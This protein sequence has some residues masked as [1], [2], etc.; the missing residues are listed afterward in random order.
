VTFVDTSA[1]CALLSETDRHHEA[2]GAAFPTLAASGTL[3][4]HNYVVV[5]ATALVDRRL[6]RGAV[7]DL[8]DRL[9]APIAVRW[10]DQRTHAAAVA[11]LLATAGP[12]LV[13]LVSF[14]LMRRLAIDEAFTFDRDFVVHGFTLVP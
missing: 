8:H 3:I 4:T 10:I 11:A 14:E 6:G 12:S 5:E 13:D 1:L 2:A 7:R 9:L